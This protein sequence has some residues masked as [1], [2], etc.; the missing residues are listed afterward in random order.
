MLSRLQEN[1]I[2]DQRSFTSLKK[3]TA[4]GTYSDGTW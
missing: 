4:G 2:E 3:F 1:L